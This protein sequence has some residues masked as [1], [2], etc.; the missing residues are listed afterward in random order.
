M[1]RTKSGPSLLSVLFHV[2]MTLITGGFWLVVL[3]IWFILNNKK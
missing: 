2:F 1:S 3:V